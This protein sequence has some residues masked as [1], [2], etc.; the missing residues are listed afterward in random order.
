MVDPGAELDLGWLEG[1][2][3]GE[4]NVQE[5]DSTFIDRT[6][7]SKNGA[8]PLKEIVSFRSSTAVWGRVK[9]DGAKLFLDSFSGSCQSLGHFGSASLLLLALLR[10][11]IAAASLRHGAAS[12]ASLAS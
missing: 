4:V 12:F 1:I 11:L 10:S 6:W 9:R 3:R 5:E 8:D 2:L 7:W